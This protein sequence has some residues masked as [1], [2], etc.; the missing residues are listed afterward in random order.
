MSPWEIQQPFSPLTPQG[1]EPSI[2]Q[3][4][5]SNLADQEK[6]CLLEEDSHKTK[7][8][9]HICKTQKANLLN[10]N[11]KELLSSPLTFTIQHSVSQ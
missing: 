7:C 10:Y 1:L 3:A 6:T 9:G 5:I 11:E 8:R 4:Q 2:S